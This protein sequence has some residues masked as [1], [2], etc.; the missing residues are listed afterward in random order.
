MKKVVAGVT[1][2]VL[3]GAM[4]GEAEAAMK[5]VSS[6]AKIKSGKLVSKKT[7]MALKGHVRYKSKVYYNGKPFNGV[8]DST[9]YKKGTRASGTYKGTVYRKGQAYT[10]VI[11]EVYYKKRGQ[12]EW[13]V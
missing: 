5:K 11:R 1:A 10:G 9:Y 2:T 12:G 4:A 3:F 8:K 6:S 13:Y 7:G